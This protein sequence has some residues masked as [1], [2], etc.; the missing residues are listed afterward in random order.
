MVLKNND[1]Q[2]QKLL[3]REIVFRIIG[4]PG[5]NNKIRFAK[6][7]ANVINGWECGKVFLV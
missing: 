5:G 3:K 4:A 6:T 7:V 1:A 2:R